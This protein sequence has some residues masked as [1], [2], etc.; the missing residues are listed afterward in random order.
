M[1][2]GTLLHRHLDGRTLRIYLPPSYGGSGQFPVIYMQDGGDLFVDTISEIEMKFFAGSLQELIMI[3]IE[4][5]NRLAEYTPWYAKALT[6]QHLDFAGHGN[7][8]V[9]V[10][11]N[12]IKPFIDEQYSTLV[13]LCHTGIMGYSLGGL[14]ALCAV[15][16]YPTVFGRVAC[17]SGSFWYQGFVDFIRQAHVPQ[18]RR[19]IYFDIGDLEGKYKSN[20]QSYMLDNTLQIVRYLKEQAIDR[21]DVH[22]YIDHGA[23]HEYEKFVKR[24]PSAL[25]WLFETS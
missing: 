14:I 19:R 17:L 1:M 7:E 20:R 2:D 22:L 12:K 15:Y 13:G 24:F 25:K 6:D 18:A 3:G 9:D 10:I 16:R 8:Y 4:S 11:V 21:Q 5:D 23:A